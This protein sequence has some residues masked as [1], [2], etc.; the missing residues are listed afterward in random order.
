M[1]SH[2]EDVVMRTYQRPP[3]KIVIKYVWVGKKIK[4]IKIVWITV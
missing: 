2:L 3:Q 4:K 1:Q